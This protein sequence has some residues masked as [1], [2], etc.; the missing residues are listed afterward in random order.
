MGRRG[1][2]SSGGSEWGRSGGRWR[3]VENGCERCRVVE[4]GGQHWRAVE[5]SGKQW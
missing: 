3:V 2:P 1:W 4:N 5:S